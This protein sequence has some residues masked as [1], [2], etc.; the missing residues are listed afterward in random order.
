[1]LLFLFGCCYTISA[2]Q[3][4]TLTVKLDTLE[5]VQKKIDQSELDVFRDNP[6]F[7][8]EIVKSTA[9]DWWVSFKNW[10]SNLILQFFEWIFGVEKAS[11]IFNV[12]L[13]ILPYLLLAI[14]VFILIKFFINV[15]ARALIYNQKAESLVTLSEEEHIIKN[16]DIQM[17]IQEALEHKNYRLAIRYYYLL[18]L[19]LMN[20]KEIIVWELQKTNADYYREIEKIDLKKPFANIT[21]LYEY[22]WYGDFPIDENKYLKAEANFLSLKN[23]LQNG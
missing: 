16:E 17:L 14:L 10:L 1:M 21:R 13:R 11:G 7:N 22:I 20:Q 3:K 2:A 4:D 23:I 8:Y 9:P 12:L 5:L 18:T 6:D 19:R 15:N